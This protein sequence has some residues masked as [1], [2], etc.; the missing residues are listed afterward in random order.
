MPLVLRR[1]TRRALERSL[2][3]WLTLLAMSLAFMA[4]AVSRALAFANG[5][6]T[7]ACPMHAGMSQKTMSDGSSTPAPA[8]LDACPLCALAGGMPLPR[9]ETALAAPVQVATAALWEFDAA[10]LP[11]PA[12]WQPPPRGPPNWA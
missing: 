1:P 5:D 7:M 9:A 8:S 11:E 4:P 2:A 6:S 12:A 3:A 10:S